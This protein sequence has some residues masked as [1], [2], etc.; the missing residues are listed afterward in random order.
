MRIL[1]LIFALL[2]A[3][4]SGFVGLAGLEGIKKKEAEIEADK[5]KY[6][7]TVVV[8]DG[9]MA[10][11]KRA[12]YALIAGIPLGV[13]GGFLA[14]A[15]KGKI[16]ALLLLIAYV[17]PVTI[18]VVGVGLDFTED[19]VKVILIAPAGLVLGALFAFFVKPRPPA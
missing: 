3:A 7:Q 1:A 16:A 12:I 18:L 9:K 2:G 17:V 10:N 15:R 6:G 19:L 8:D 14:V 5:A 13:I 11:L 4:A